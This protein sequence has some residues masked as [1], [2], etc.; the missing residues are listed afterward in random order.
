LRRNKNIHSFVPLTRHE[1]RQEIQTPCIDM[2]W[3]LL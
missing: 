1:K 3:L 2:D